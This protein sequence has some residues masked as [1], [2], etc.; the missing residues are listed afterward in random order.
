MEQIQ[1]AQSGE[2]DAYA[3]L[4]APLLV[5]A[6]RLAYGILQD[7]SAAEDAVQDAAVLSWRRLDQLRSGHS[8]RPW[9]L[10]IVV[11]RCHDVRRRRWW[12]EVRLPDFVHRPWSDEWAWLEGAVLREAVAGLPDGIREAIVLHFYLDL[13]LEEVSATLGVGL[14]G[15]KARINR[16]LRRLRRALQ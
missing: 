7:H 9:F 2:K 6:I 12:R 5:D 4:L 1:D 15:V 8:F 10:R 14:S 3:E 13:P 11:N 16:G